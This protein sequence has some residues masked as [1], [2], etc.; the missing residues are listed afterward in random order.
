MKNETRLLGTADYIFFQK[1]DNVF[2][3]WLLF[4]KMPF[5]KI[6]TSLIFLEHFSSILK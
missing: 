1:D 2:S 5:Q 4:F 3:K 6:K